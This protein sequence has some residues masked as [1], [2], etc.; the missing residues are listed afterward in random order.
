MRPDGGDGRHALDEGLRDRPPADQN[1][2]R[3]FSKGFVALPGVSPAL[4]RAQ[5]SQNN[6][7][8]SGSGQGWADARGILAVRRR[9]LR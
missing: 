9:C 2:V 4:A 7:R 5:T 6:S 8:N 3:N 1:E